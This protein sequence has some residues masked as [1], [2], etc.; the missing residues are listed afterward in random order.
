MNKIS[1][2]ILYVLICVIC[3]FLGHFLMPIYVSDE[4]SYCETKGGHY[5][6]MYSDLT[7]NY[8]S[9][10]AIPEKKIF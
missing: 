10:C 8:L 5:L 6:L 4:L 9:K 1:K 7:N 2:Y 3:F